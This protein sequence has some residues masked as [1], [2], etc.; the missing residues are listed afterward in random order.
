[1]DANSLFEESNSMRDA[2]AL[3][4][5]TD[6][7][8][9][10]AKLYQEAVIPSKRYEDAGYDIYGC[11]AD[12][13]VV[14]QPHETVMLPT[15]IASAFQPDYVMILKERGST[16]TRGIGQRSGVID[17]GYRGEWMVPVT[18][19]NDIPLLITK[20]TNQSALEALAEEYV[21]Y[22]YTKAVCQ[23]ILLEVPASEIREVSYERL[24]Q[25]ESLRGTG[26]L[27]SSGK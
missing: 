23:A 6:T 12:E 4:P 2:S 24:Q 16:G 20:E 18:N 7:M 21:V 14:I 3:F 9:Y 13:N 10:F 1:M 15:G 8:V 25:M 11:W 5:V 27:G 26:R 17:S 19:H 22:P